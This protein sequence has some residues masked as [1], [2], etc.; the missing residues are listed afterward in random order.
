MGEKVAMGMSLVALGGLAFYLGNSGRKPNQT[1]VLDVQD[2]NKEIKDFRIEISQE[3]LADLKERLERTIYPDEIIGANWD[4]GTSENFLKELI[5]Y[6]KQEY[7]WKKWEAHLNSFPQFK[8]E[9]DDLEIHFIHI[10]S[11]EKDATPIILIHGWPGSFFEFHKLIPKLIDPVAHGGKST[12]AFHV[13]VPSLPGYGFSQAPK[14]PGYDIRKVATSFAKLMARLGYDQYF[15]QGGDWGSMISSYIAIQDSSHCR[16]IHLN[17]IITYPPKGIFSTIK[18][19]LDFTLL[20]SW[21]LTKLELSK[22]Q[23]IKKFVKEE[24]AYY[25]LQG[26]KPQTLGYGLADSPVG[27]A[28]W[29]LEKFR[30]WSDCEGNV[31]TRF[32]K[33][34]LLTNIMIYWVTNTITSS[35]RLYYECFKLKSFGEVDSYVSVPTAFAYFPKE[36]VLTRRTWAENKYHIVR[37][38]EM[39]SGGHFAALEE[40][41]LLCQ[42][43]R[44]FVTDIKGS[45]LHS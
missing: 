22:F 29:I 8:T 30:A 31:E 7:D 24:T 36:L 43:I 35:A 2:K 32:T 4:Y 9:I 17:M 40:P 13:V 26:T 41:Q 23:N 16:G 11:Q 37:W 20:K 3:K 38:T 34:E 42:D 12:D 6:W 10:R 28:A 44:A 39:E 25:K 45:I 14:F 15:A 5:H 33:D 19:A 1:S 18:T 21:A 27:L